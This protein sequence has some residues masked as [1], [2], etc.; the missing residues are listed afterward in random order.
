MNELKFNMNELKFGDIVTFVEEADHPRRPVD[1]GVCLED[2][3]MPYVY[4]GGN[5]PGSA[6]RGV[7][8]Y[9]YFEVI[10]IGSDKKLAEELKKETLV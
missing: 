4:I 2:G 1:L 5:Y 7:Y 9:S 6:G 10:L 8:P 3:S